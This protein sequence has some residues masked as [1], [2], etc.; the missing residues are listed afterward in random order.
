[1]TIDTWNYMDESPVI[2]QSVSD[3]KEYILNNA[4]M[5]NAN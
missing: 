4:L 2:L 5:E 1:M 3:R